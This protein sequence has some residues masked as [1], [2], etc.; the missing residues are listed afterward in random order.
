M[1]SCANSSLVR[2]TRAAQTIIRETGLS[3]RPAV[4]GERVSG[5]YRRNILLAS[6][7]FAMLVFSLVPWKP[8][9]QQRLEQKVIVMFRSGNTYWELGR[10]LVLSH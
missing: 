5:V 10:H 9:I 1:I 7:R 4:D 8:V 2:W 6:G 3:Y